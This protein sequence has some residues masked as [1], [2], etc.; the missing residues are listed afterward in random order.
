MISENPNNLALRSNIKSGDE[1]EEL[2]SIFDTMLDKVENYTNLQSRF[3]SDVSHE[4]RTP[5][6]IIKGHI[7]LLQRWGKDDSEILEESLNATAHEADRMA[8]MINDMLDMIRVQGSFDGHQNDITNL[9]SSIETVIGNFKVLREDF[10]FNWTNP[11]L[12]L[13]G[14]IYKNHFEQAL[15]ILIDNAIKYS[16]KEKEITIDLRLQSTNQA[17]VTVTDKGEGI[18]QEDIEHIFERFYRSDKSRNRTSTQAGLGIGLS[19]L[20]QIVEG[21]NLSMEVKSQLHG[22]STFILYIPLV[23][24]LQL[25]N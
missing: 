5:V 10:I 13:A 4:L 15:M 17:I 20:H 23:D 19:I 24:P 9:E 25:I 11:K 18:S 16:Q 2:S 3:I 8:I 12:D 7:G 21:Y 22:G 6:A 14:K 1:I